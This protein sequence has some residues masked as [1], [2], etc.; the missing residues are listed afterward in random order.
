MISSKFLDSVFIIFNMNREEIVKFLSEL[1]CIKHRNAQSLLDTI[2]TST[3]QS[4]HDFV[5]S[6]GL[7]LVRSCIQ[8]CAACGFREFQGLFWELSSTMKAEDEN[9]RQWGFA[10]TAKEEDSQS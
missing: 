4:F 9:Q 7:L 1:N 10:L 3:L 8:H 2:S 6:S 5:I